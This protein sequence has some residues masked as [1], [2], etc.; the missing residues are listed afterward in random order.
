MQF[1]IGVSVV[2]KAAPFRR[3][4]IETSS[5]IHGAEVGERSFLT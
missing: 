5:N 4:P 2:S 1:E 3:N